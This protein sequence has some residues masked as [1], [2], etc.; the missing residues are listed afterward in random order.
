MR[1]YLSLQSSTTLPPGQLCPKPTSR[2]HRRSSPAAPWSRNARW[3]AHCLV[4]LWAPSAGRRGTVAP[5]RSHP[6]VPPSCSAA[7][8]KWSTCSRWAQSTAALFLRKSNAVFPLSVVAAAVFESTLCTDVTIN[9]PLFLPPGLCRCSWYIQAVFG[10]AA[11]HRHHPPP[12]LRQPNLKRQQPVQRQPGVA[13][14]G[15]PRAAWA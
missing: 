13:A 2:R 4:I 6:W 3:W 1:W 5:S 8:S 10:A 15:H 12:S 9:Y 11:G 7:S 14:H